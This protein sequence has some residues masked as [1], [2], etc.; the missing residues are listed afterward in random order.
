[1]VKGV[2]IFPWEPK[3]VSVG[4]RTWDGQ[5]E[6][7]RFEVG[8]FIGHL[9]LYYQGKDVCFSTDTTEALITE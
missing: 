2:L 6:E 4:K 7:I 1:M 5:G 8:T 3:E 9:Q